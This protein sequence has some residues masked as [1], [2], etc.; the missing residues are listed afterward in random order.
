MKTQCCTKDWGAFPSSDLCTAASSCFSVFKGGKCSPKL[1]L[2]WFSDL[3]W[4]QAWAESISCGWGKHRVMI[5]PGSADRGSVCALESGISTG[6]NHPQLR[7]VL[8]RLHSP[9]PHYINRWVLVQ[10]RCRGT[11]DTFNYE[12]VTSTPDRPG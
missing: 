6:V 9:S 5:G 4:G 11:C 10:I 2:G 12:S 1:G 8:W 3:T 7:E